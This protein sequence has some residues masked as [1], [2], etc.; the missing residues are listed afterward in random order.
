M[1]GDDLKKVAKPLLGK[2]DEIVC[3]LSG[4]RKATMK[5]ATDGNELDIV[6]TNF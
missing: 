6:K 5:I 2:E 1:A 4:N 3:R